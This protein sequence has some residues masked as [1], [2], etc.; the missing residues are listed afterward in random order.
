M[1][2]KSL[3]ETSLEAS[4]EVA[5]RTLRKAEAAFHEA[6]NNGMRPEMI[7]MR[8]NQ[9]IAAQQIYYHIFAELQEERRN[10]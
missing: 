7:M 6:N 2:E 10:R 9:S 1:A 4:L 3:K 8:S 5:K